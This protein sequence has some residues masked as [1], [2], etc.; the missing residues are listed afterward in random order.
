MF[1]K[2]EQTEILTE[3]SNRRLQSIHLVE[4]LRQWQLEFQILQNEC[5]SLSFSFVLAVNKVQCQRE[6]LKSV[7]CL[8]V[9]MCVWVCE[10]VCVF[11]CARKRERSNNVTHI[12]SNDFSWMRN[13]KETQG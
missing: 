10:C 12:I 5:Y 3:K 1:Q 13:N 11:V 2:E 4:N 8:S 6:Q 7:R 9:C